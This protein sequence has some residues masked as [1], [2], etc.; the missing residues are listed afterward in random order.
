MPPKPIFKYKFIPYYV[1]FAIYYEAYHGEA[2]RP[3]FAVPLAFLLHNLGLSWIS[4]I[5][6]VTTVS[7]LDVVHI[8]IWTDGVHEPMPSQD[9]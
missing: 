2:F 9:S 7:I 4:L 6:S 1:D 5:Y 3:A 8:S